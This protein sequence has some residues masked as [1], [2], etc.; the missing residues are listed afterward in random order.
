MYWAF[1]LALTV[2]T[3]DGT[4]GEGFPNSVQS[5]IVGIALL[6]SIGILALSFIR[7]NRAVREWKRQQEGIS[8]AR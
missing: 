3:I 6:I 2:A 5:D 4:V 1:G 7:L 8:R